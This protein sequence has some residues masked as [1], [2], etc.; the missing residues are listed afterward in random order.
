[1]TDAD[2][3]ELWVYSANHEATK[4]PYQNDEV[5]LHGYLMNY[6]GKIEITNVEI[7]GKKIYPEIDAVTRGTSTITYNIEHGAVNAEAPKSAKNNAE[8]QFSITP[9]QGYKVDRVTVAGDEVTAENG[10]YKA[11]VK[12]NTVVNIDI[13][14]EG[15][16]VKTAVMAYPATDAAST[17]MVEGNNAA[18]VGLDPEVFNVESTNTT[19]IYA[20][21][22]KA[23]E[24]FPVNF[25]GDNVFFSNYELTQ[26]KAYQNAKP[27]DMAKVENNPDETSSESLDLDGL[28]F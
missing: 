20:G 28:E 22:N 12:G 16:E 24:V 27:T 10:V 13:S 18:T 7:S 17:N 6:G 21:L 4:T 26:Q 14:R 8:F 19:S 1:M 15:V 9:E 11:Y 5:V 23:G 25:I 3:K 2:D